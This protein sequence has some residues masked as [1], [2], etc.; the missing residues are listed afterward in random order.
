MYSY[1]NELM[2]WNHFSFILERNV[3]NTINRKPIN[4]AS[5]VAYDYAKIQ[6]K[7]HL[8]PEQ[9]TSEGPSLGE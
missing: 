7:F 4:V 9:N 1:S 3:H 6:Q 2:L 8:L 5:V